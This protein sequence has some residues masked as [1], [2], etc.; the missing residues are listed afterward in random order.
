MANG[1]TNL[2]EHLD[3]VLF[4]Q[5]QIRDRVAEMGA[6]ITREFAGEPLT[7]VAVLQG[8]ALFMADLIREIRLPLEI[9]SI[10]V[11]SYHGATESSGTV[12]F[13]Q[14]RMPNLRGRNVLILDDILDTGKTMKLACRELAL[15]G[16]SSIRTCVFLDKPKRRSNGFSADW[17]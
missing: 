10:S 3:R 2:Y 4:D 15:L 9:D 16:P 7:I 1:E 17:V 12:T 13:H 6:E 11:A 8:G 5:V 14:T